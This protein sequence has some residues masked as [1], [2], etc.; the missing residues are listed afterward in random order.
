MRHLATTMSIIGT[1]LISAAAICFFI[2]T[3]ATA[4]IYALYALGGIALAVGL[5]SFIVHFASEKNRPYI[6]HRS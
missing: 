5:I 4:G 2:S 1:I 3:A 6:E